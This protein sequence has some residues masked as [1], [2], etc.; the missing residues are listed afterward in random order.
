MAPLDFNADIPSSEPLMEAEEQQETR[1][2]RN[3]GTMTTRIDT[4]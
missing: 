1:H 3:Q 4:M 2:L